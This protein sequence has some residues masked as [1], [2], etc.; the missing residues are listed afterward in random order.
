VLY[1]HE[2]LLFQIFPV[3]YKE[4]RSIAVAVVLNVP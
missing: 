1:F 2:Q 4:I 3:T